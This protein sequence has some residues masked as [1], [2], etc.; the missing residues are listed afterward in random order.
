MYLSVVPLSCTSNIFC[1][2]VESV[3]AVL[4]N[5]FRKVVAIYLDEYASYNDYLSRSVVASDVDSDILFVYC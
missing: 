4:I 5:V 3:K 2:K 1:F